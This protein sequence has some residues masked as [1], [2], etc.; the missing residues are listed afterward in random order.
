MIPQIGR[1]RSWLRDHPDTS[2]DLLQM[3]KS[4]FAAAFAWWIATHLLG[5]QLP[6]LAPWTALMTVHATVY[7]T[8][9]RGLQMMAATVIGVLLTG[10]VAVPLGVNTVSLTIAMVLGLLVTRL[11]ALRE[12]GVAAAT[13]ALF[14][15]AGRE[16]SNVTLMIDR[17]QEVCLGAAIGMIVNLLVIPPLRHREAEWYT[18]DI[19]R[20]MGELLTGMGAELRESWSTDRSAAWVQRTVEMDSVLEEAWSQVRLSHESA[21]LNPRAKHWSEKDHPS[22]TLGK[23]HEGISHLRHLVR[24]IDDATTAQS[25]W[26]D[27]F[28]QRWSSIAED[29]GRRLIDPAV[30]LTTP[31][32]ALDDL[33]RDM[34]RED[35]PN[36]HWPQYGT[37]ISGLRQIA[38][39][40]DDV[41]PEGTTDSAR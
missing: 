18:T 37:L 29:C 3:L 20:R 12:E 11:P 24:T 32:R 31:T 8:V 39:I 21:R 14:I 22:V 16:Q 15:M 34:S 7:A 30:D 38:V 6:F 13:T 9:R 35:L 2:S 5:S 1:T 40:A 10:I 19:H 36:L 41:A 25:E 28:R 23:L 33:A 4:A 26:D 17:I 27:E